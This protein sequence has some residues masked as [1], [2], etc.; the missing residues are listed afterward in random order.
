MGTRVVTVNDVL[1]GHVA[2][3]IECLDR[4][5]LN[6]Y[7]PILQSSGQVVAFLCQSPLHPHNPCHGLAGHI[8]QAR[9]GPAARSGHPAA[10]GRQLAPWPPD[11]SVAQR[12]LLPRA[13][14]AARAG[15]ASPGHHQ[16]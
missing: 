3:D 1:E 10:L 4:I 13:S 2:L 9:H 15:D 5:Y 7:V 16:P 6:G 12:Q 11:A 8:R 14:R